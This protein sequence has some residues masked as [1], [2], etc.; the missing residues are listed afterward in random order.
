[1]TRGR[2]PNA[3]VAALRERFGDRLRE[4]E[5]LARY[6]SAR[7]GGPADVV[8]VAGS[9][10]ELAEAAMVL[11]HSQLPLRVL[12]GGSNVLVS[13]AGVRGAVILNQARDVKFRKQAG[14][15]SV[16]AESGA[17]LGSV[18]RRAVEKGLSGIE[19]A[20]TVPGTVG[21]AVVG[22]AGAHGGDVAGSLEMA[23]ILQRDGS[24][25]HWSA[26]ELDYAYR[27]SRLKR[28]PGEAVVLSA[29]FR[30][31]LSTVEATKARTAEFV[32]HRQSTQ[33]PGASW[34]SM[35]KN[36][37][38]DHAGRL[39]EA[40][41]LKGAREGDVEISTQHGN[42]FINRGRARA[43]DAWA[44]ITRVQAAVEATTGVRLE[45]EVELLGD[46]QGHP[47][48]TGAGAQD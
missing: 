22:N 6:T 16:H 11:W 48:G 45:L 7:I 4:L 14:R 21:G 39:I 29:D 31:V 10:D 12:G 34:G 1:M 40:A 26:D 8:I 2:L 25:V 18:A 15:E 42:F 44:M 38:G 13:D 9:I 35:F 23:E 37:P 43:S 30:L 27:D 47:A 36:P 41:G 19:W 3:A 32:A 5:P 20:A 46:W 17:V 24:V 28:S 33:P